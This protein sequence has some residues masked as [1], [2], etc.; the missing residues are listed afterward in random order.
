LV[1]VRPHGSDWQI[2]VWDTGIGVAEEVQQMIYLPYFRQENAWGYPFCGAWLRAFC[3]G[4]LRG[5]D[6]S[7]VGYAIQARAWFALLDSRA[8]GEHAARL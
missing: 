3:G 2:E 7:A 1:G 4:A 5:A 6:E 8:Q